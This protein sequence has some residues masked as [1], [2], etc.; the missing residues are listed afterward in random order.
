M[1]FKL[2]LSLKTWSVLMVLLYVYCSMKGTQRVWQTSQIQ[3]P[4]QPVLDVCILS[5]ELWSYH[6]SLLW[7]ILKKIL[8][9]EFYGIKPFI[10]KV[11]KI[12][13]FW[14]NFRVSSCHIQKND[15]CPRSS[16]FYTVKPGDI[17]AG[18]IAAQ[19]WIFFRFGKWKS[20]LWSYIFVDKFH[21]MLIS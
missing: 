1:P 3:L 5:I 11:P 21:Y 6:Q 18:D 4:K 10:Q 2:S 19:K 7:Q 17:Y 8:Q 12:W 9:T 20:S 13:H 16:K 15:K 14:G